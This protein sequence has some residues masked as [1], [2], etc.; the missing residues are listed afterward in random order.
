LK[1]N[2]SATIRNAIVPA[3][4]YRPNELGGVTD[5]DSYPI[6]T[7]GKGRDALNA[8]EPTLLRFWFD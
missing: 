2:P 6:V 1:T 3:T 8:G 4:D 5:A 7:V